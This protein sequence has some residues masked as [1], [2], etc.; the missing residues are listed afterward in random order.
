M[1]FDGKQEGRFNII[2]R[3]RGESYSKEALPWNQ[4]GFD[5]AAATPEGWI[6]ASFTLRYLMY[7]F[8]GGLTDTSSIT[9]MK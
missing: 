4:G 2:R 5:A 9:G 6:F 8:D 3:R 7:S 1:F